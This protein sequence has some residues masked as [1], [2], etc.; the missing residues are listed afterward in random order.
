MEPS[1]GCDGENKRGRRVTQ[2]FPESPTEH[3][4]WFK[5]QKGIVL[6]LE[7]ASPQ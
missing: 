4:W 5:Q 2:S 7:D 1:Q 3:A 6:V